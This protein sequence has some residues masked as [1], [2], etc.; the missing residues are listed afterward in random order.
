MLYSAT[1]VLKDGLRKAGCPNFHNDYLRDFECSV[2]CDIPANEDGD[3]PS[4]MGEEPKDWE[5][6]NFGCGCS[7]AICCYHA[8]MQFERD[9]RCPTCRKPGAL[10]GSGFMLKDHTKERLY[11]ETVLECP[12]EGC[13][14][15]AKP[16]ELV[17]HLKRCTELPCRCPMHKV[18]CNW[19]GSPVELE[20]HMA[21]DRHKPV[22]M[23]FI[24]HQLEETEQLFVEVKRLRECQHDTEVKIDSLTN[25]LDSFVSKMSEY[26]D[27]Q[28][29]KVAQAQP[30]ALDKNVRPACLNTRKRE[31]AYWGIPESGPDVEIEYFRQRSLRHKLNI[32][33]YP[34]AHW[35]RG[36]AIARHLPDDADGS[37]SD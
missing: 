26:M 18:G 13:A 33:R 36:D 20:E 2:C 14:H 32:D 31:R 19:V 25:T 5:Y 17:K 24:T 8:R 9:T 16:F 4:N 21:D 11:N 10:S 7:A 23:M 1:N 6:V 3:E 12:L 29:K 37:D 15:R 35:A 22:T 30:N 27:N 34:P 28:G